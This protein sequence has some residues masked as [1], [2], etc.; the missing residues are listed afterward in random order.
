MYQ[1]VRYSHFL[2]LAGELPLVELDFFFNNR[3]GDETSRWNGV[4]IGR[5][6]DEGKI[7]ETGPRFCGIGDRKGGEFCGVG[8]EGGVES[9][10]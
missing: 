2:G 9:T 8:K 6:G 4:K 10:G 7:G 1:F 3:S 5:V